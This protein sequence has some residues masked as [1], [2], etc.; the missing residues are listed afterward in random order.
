VLPVRVFKK[1]SDTKGE[2]LMKKP[3]LVLFVAFVITVAAAGCTK[4]SPSEEGL[5]IKVG[6]TPVPHAEILEFVKPALEEQGIKLQVVEF[7]DYVQPN[8]SLADG[9]LDANYFQHIPYLEEFAKDHDLDLT[10]NAKVHIEPMGVY[11]QSIAS[12]EDLEAGALVA[13]PNDVTNGGR[14][15]LLLEKAGIIKLRA[16][17]GIEATINDVQANYKGIEITEL[18]AAALPRV[19]QDV[20][21]AVINTNYALEAGLVPYKDALFIEDGDSPYVN[22]VAIRSE[23][24]DDEALLKL[25]EA[26]NSEEVKGFIEQKYKGAILPAFE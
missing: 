6:A 7:T 15:L 19:L 1:I 17:V 9:E 18:E 22:V 20:D 26:L 5:V 25:A 3:L 8:L 14:A 10:Y 23:D 16:G 11:S 4:D 21:L 2:H 24:R 13:I 12:I